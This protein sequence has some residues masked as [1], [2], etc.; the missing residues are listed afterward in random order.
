MTNQNYG[1]M[2]GTVTSKN[3][4]KTTS[5]KIETILGSFLADRSLNRFEAE[6]LHDHC[7]NSTVSTLQNGHGVKI[8]R[9]REIAPC[10]GGAL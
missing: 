5:T 3:S 1:V 10:L 4:A 2:P 6:P 7:L 9:A 8:D